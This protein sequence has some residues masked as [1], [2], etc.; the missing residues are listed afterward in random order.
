MS[1][2]PG[3]HFVV[4]CVCCASLLR[5]PWYHFFLVEEVSNVRVENLRGSSAPCGRMPQI[6]GLQMRDSY[7]RTFVFTT[8]AA[9]ITTYVLPSLP[10][11]QSRGAFLL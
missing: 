9:P 7:E 8:F 10:F 1:P 11:S 2:Q 4:F 6:P 5:R 3:A